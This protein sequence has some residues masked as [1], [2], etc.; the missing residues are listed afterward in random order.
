MKF[1]QK[2]KDGGPDSPVT[3]FFIVEIKSLFSIVLLKFNPG[4]RESFHSH[5]FNAITFWL[6]GKVW[7]ETIFSKSPKFTRWKAGQV[8]T[9]ARSFMHR[10]ATG[11]PAYALSIRGPWAKNWLEFNP[12]TEEFTKLSNGRKIE[13]RWKAFYS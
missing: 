6:K 8:K 2:A 12:E 11:E 5:A 1:F 7:E 9:T 13:S 10:I 3:G 4:M